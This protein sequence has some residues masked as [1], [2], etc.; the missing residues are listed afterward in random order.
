MKQSRALY[1]CLPTTQK[2]IFR[3]IWEINIE[4]NIS[5]EIF[6]IWNFFLKY[7]EY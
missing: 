2:A 7:D 6:P 3:Q 1:K 5:Y 4:F